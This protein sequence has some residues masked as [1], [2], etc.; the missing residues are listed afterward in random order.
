MKL[1]WTKERMAK[2]QLW[3]AV[4]DMWEQFNF[5][6]GRN[7]PTSLPPGGAPSSS[8]VRAKQK[9]LQDIRKGV[10]DAKKRYFN[11]R[12]GA[13][14]CP[15]MH[16]PPRLVLTRLSRVPVVLLFRRCMRCSRTGFRPQNARKGGW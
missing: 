10:V 6:A 11:V 8:V 15:F 3:E 9:A 12:F 7:V 5:L 16:A 2:M 4:K 1:L 14:L 13:A